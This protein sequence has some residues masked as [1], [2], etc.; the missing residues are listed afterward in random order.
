GPAGAAPAVAEPATTTCCSASSTPGTR[1]A[2]PRRRAG[3]GRRDAR[4]GALRGAVHELQHQ[5]VDRRARL[6]T[7]PEHLR[8]AVREQEELV[9][10][11]H[12][13]GGDVVDHD[14]LQRMGHLHRC[15][16]ET[17][18]LHPP[19][20]M[21]LRHARRSF[22]VRTRGSGDAE[23]EVPAGHTVASPMV[24]H[25]A[26][27]HVY[28]DAGSFDPGRFGPA[29]EEYR[30]YAADHTYTVF[31]GGRHACVGEALSR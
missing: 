23:Y 10:V 15:V 21:L 5:H 2:A 4:I 12:R 8:A 25:N 3:G 27:P 9:L 7:H 24:I 13:H 17:L 31:G 26:L 6:L 18:R 20:L 14:A 22:V 11:R 16:K 28:E 30:A 29:R 19:S 1:T